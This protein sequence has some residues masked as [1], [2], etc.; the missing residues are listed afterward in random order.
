MKYLFIIAF[1][2]LGFHL[3]AKDLIVSGYY[4]NLNNDTVN[5]RFSI[6][7]K[8]GQLL[9]K[10]DASVPIIMDDIYGSTTSGLL[11]KDIPD[12]LHLQKSVVALDK[13]GSR[14]EIKPSDVKKFTIF[15][16]K[17][18]FTFVSIPVKLN[19]TDNLSP[20]FMLSLVSGKVELFQ[21][22]RYFGEPSPQK[23]T[24]YFIRKS[25]DA[26]YRY[27]DAFFYI[28]LIKYLHDWPNLNTVINDSKYK[29]LD[30]ASILEEYNQLVKENGDKI[31]NKN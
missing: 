31:I 14:N 19:F 7:F 21:T 18:T 25:D 30:I 29:T 4:I 6:P 27:D 17:D 28:S 1:L 8:K 13:V 11:R 22:T 24:I 15:A 16:E 2:F 12:L 5:T 9:S 23:E 10:K 26:I 20:I 3:K